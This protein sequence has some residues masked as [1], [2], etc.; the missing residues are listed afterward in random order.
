MKFA[1][2]GERMLSGGGHSGGED[3]DVRDSQ[4]DLVYNPWLR[5]KFDEL[6]PGT[7]FSMPE[8]T[9]QVF[10]RWTQ[11]ACLAL[12]AAEIKGY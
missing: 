1:T 7:L 6:N 8:H 9:A 3:F 4:F 12:H 10:K 2:T 5:P 11:K